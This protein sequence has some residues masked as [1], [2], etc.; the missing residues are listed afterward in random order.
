VIDYKWWMVDFGFQHKFKMLLTFAGA[1]ALVYGLICLALLRGQNR[2][3]FQ[4]TA[5]IAF[6]PE[7]LG[8]PYEE[9]WLPIS[10]RA[11]QRE[12]LHGW[13]LPASSPAQKVLLYLHGNGSNVAGNLE[14][15]YRF[16]QL[17]FEVF[18][19]DYRG[20]GKSAGNFPTEAQVYED[21]QIAL[22]YL[23]QQRQIEPR[24]ITL[25]GHS[26][27]GAIA[28]DLA[29]RN[30]NLAGLIIEGSF[31]SMRD[32]VDRVSL[33]SIF[34]IELILTHRF[35]SLSKIKSLTLPILYIHGTSDATIPYAMSQILFE[36]TQAP[37]KLLLVPGAGHNNVAA[38]SGEE[39]LQTV[40]EF[41]QW[42][43]SDRHQPIGFS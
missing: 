41:M 35:D 40:R 1:I 19:F 32:L 20:Y 26:L 21:A 17:G 28:I 23:V 4:P 15:A 27:G 8:L 34:P 30:P 5:A 3:I 14:Q 24:A 31:T 10:D 2:L 25:Y 39:Y 16:R 12:Q 11:N 6:T 37:K 29:A 43:Q 18:L 36:A 38:T 22:D 42:V 9:V 33:Y 7:N 13:W